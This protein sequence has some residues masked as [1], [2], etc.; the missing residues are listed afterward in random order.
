M[1]IRFDNFTLRPLEKNDAVQFLALIDNNR[2][3]LR[4][5]F[6][7]TSQQI[8]DLGTCK[9]YIKQKTAE[10][11]NREIYSFVLVDEKKDLQGLFILKNIDWW[12]P[13]GELAYFID[14][15]L[16][17]KGIMTRALSEI[18]TY[19]FDTLDMNKLFILTSTDNHASRKI[20]EK[21]GFKIEGILRQNYRIPSG[22]VDNVHYGL[23][24]AER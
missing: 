17:G 20:A 24:K 2:A 14:K 16:E 13:K 9:K 4:D 12:V 10:A 21:N 15:D 19:C 1:T 5:Y 3:R 11:G 18:V 22:L 23:L 8:T 7:N 6:P